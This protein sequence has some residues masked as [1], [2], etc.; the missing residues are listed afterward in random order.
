MIHHIAL[1]IIAILVSVIVHFSLVQEQQLTTAT[2]ATIYQI[3]LNIIQLVLQT[4]IVRSY[5]CF[6][7][8]YTILYIDYGQL[9]FIS[10]MIYGKKMFINMVH[11]YTKQLS[12]GL[13]LVS[14]IITFI[15]NCIL[16]ITTPNATTTIADEGGGGVLLLLLQ[17]NVVYVNKVYTIL[18]SSLCLLVLILLFLGRLLLPLA[19]R[20]LMKKE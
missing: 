7:V 1:F 18:A 2:T 9:Y 20:R 11:I 16:H 19:N 6:I 3:V 8:L 14:C 17:W 10:N 12:T 5:L 13:I 4:I 15:R